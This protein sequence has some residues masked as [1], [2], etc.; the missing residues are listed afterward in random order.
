MLFNKVTI[1]IDDDG[2]GVDGY[3]DGG[4]GG[5]GIDI[6]QILRVLGLMMINFIYQ[7]YYLN[8]IY[9]SLFSDY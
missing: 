2:D 6:I 1:I 3:N 7:D 4:G 8:I 9:L 5:G